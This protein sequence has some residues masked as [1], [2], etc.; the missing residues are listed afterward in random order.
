[1]KASIM[2]LY[3]SPC[4]P[5]ILASSSTSW[6]GDLQQRN[7]SFGAMIGPKIPKGF[8]INLFFVLG[9][10]LTLVDAN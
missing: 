3:L 4:I 5:S 8:A 9:I 2:H 7:I 10:N 1:M 6:S